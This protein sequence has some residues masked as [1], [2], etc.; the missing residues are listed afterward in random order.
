MLGSTQSQLQFRHTFE[1]ARVISQYAELVSFCCH[2][3]DPFSTPPR[4]RTGLPSVSK[5]VV[6]PVSKSVIIAIIQGIPFDRVFLQDGLVNDDTDNNIPFIEALGAALI[7][8]TYL[9]PF[10]DFASFYPRNAGQLICLPTTWTTVYG[11]V[12]SF[13]QE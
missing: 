1:S 3:M 13:Q 9:D 2:D 5:K 6:V 8:T 7:E 10:N 4:F 12:S 11:N